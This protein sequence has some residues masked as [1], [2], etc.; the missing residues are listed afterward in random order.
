M[1]AAITDT[2]LKTVNTALKSGFIA[3]AKKDIKEQDTPKEDQKDLDTAADGSATS[4]VSGSN[5]EV[6]GSVDLAQKKA[7]TKK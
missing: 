2:S 6:G 4:I 5:G 1:K 3:S 7:F